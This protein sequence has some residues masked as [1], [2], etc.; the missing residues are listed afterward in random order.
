MAN[1]VGSLNSALILSE[2]MKCKR[3]LYYLATEVLGYDRLTAEFHRPILERMDAL[4]AARMKGRGHHSLWLWAREHYKTTC[5]RA[6]VIQDYLWD[7]LDTHVWWHAVEEHAE[8]TAEAIG[9][10]IQ[11]NKRLRRIAP[12]GM[13]PSINAKRFIGRHGFRLPCSNLSMAASF[14]AWGAGSE[15]T[16]GHARR[17][18][19]DDI[20]TRADIESGQMQSKRNWYRSTVLNVVEKSGWLDASG[21]RKAHDD[22]Y[23]DWSE[24]PYWQVE[25]RACLEDESQHP[26]VQGRPVLLPVS[27]VRR[28]REEM[29]ESDFAMEMQNDPMPAADIPWDPVTCEHSM[30]HDKAMAGEGQNIVI[31]DPAPYGGHDRKDGD[32][33]FWALAVIRVKKRGEI[34][35][36]DSTVPAKEYIL[37]YGEQSQKWSLDQG[38]SRML[39]LKDQWKARLHVFDYSGP[40]GPIYRDKISEIA[41]T[42]QSARACLELDTVHR[43]RNDLFLGFCA[44]ASAVRFSI[45]TNVPEAFRSAFLHQCR[46]WRPMPNN[47]N[48]LRHDD[49]ANAVA[50]LADPAVLRLAPDSGFDSQWYYR[51]RMQGRGVNAYGGRHLSW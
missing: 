16:G 13:C 8:D 38:I 4:R 39:A 40:A 14:R 50:Y 43:G 3:N 9:S 35:Q 42:T 47:K 37:L 45:S 33:D 6:Q 1:I 19:L 12:E 24:S 5:R 41:N 26:D 17:G 31:S 27:L 21:T 7:P 44:V 25:L 23:A 36:G 15:A 22:I 51:R 29:G 48:G 32:K 28:A 18:Y 30:D 46:R 2:R 10:M 34:L 11:T 20:I 49:A